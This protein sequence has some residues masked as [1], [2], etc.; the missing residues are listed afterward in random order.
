M[1][2]FH[3]YC[4]LGATFMD[5]WTVDATSVRDVLDRSEISKRLGSQGI[6]WL[7]ITVD[8]DQPPQRDLNRTRGAR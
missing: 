4:R 8:S 3:I 7:L 6:D 2:R 5:D 1:K